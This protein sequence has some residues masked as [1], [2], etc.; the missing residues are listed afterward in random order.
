MVKVHYAYY[1]VCCGFSIIFFTCVDWSDFLYMT[2]ITEYTKEVKVNQNW[3]EFV[4]RRRSLRFDYKLN[5]CFF[6]TRDRVNVNQAS[7]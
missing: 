1:V 5:F 7:E 4:V 6:L 3:I 2:S